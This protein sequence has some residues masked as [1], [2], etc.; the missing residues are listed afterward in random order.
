LLT[1]YLVSQGVKAYQRHRDRAFENNTDVYGL[2]Q[3]VAMG[4]YQPLRESGERYNSGLVRQARMI[5]VSRVLNR[6]ELIESFKELQEHELLLL[7]GIFRTEG[8]SEMYEAD[9]MEVYLCLEEM[10]E[11]QEQQ[12]EQAVEQEGDSVSA[13]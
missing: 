6:K 8:Y 4:S 11:Q 2:T 1:R 7:Y 10:L 3:L 13:A 5:T 9:I 12:Q